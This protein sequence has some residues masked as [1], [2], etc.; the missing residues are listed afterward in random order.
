[1]MA[2]MMKILPIRSV[3]VPEAPTRNTNRSVNQTSDNNEEVTL[4]IQQRTTMDEEEQQVGLKEVL[5][6]ARSKCD[7]VIRQANVSENFDII[8]KGLVAQ[9]T[10]RTLKEMKRLPTSDALSEEYQ[11][12][13]SQGLSK[14][15]QAG[16][17]REHLEKWKEAEKQIVAA[18][19]CLAN[20]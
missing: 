9:I 1:M 13:A 2:P 10:K 19:K 6:A 18:V 17:V 8:Q 4:R 7:E 5:E 3:A 11:Q 16:V 15:I 12:L 20:D 14:K